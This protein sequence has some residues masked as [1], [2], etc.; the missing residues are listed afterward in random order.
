MTTRG[1]GRGADDD[2]TDRP[3]S[4][5]DVLSGLL[6][7]PALAGGVAVGNLARRWGEVVGERLAGD[8]APLRLAGGILTV[9]ATSGPWGGQARFL[10]EEIRKRANEV[11]GRPLVREVRVSVDEGR[12]DARKSL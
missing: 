6:R 11:L 1:A 10:S 2:R 5:A 8:T 9:V 12:L 7:Q 4:I 3:S